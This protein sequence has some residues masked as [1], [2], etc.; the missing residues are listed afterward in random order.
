MRDAPILRR[1]S[2]MSSGRFRQD[3]VLP[4]EQGIIPHPRGA[5]SPP[6]RPNR[7]GEQIE[8]AFPM[9]PMTEPGGMPFTPAL[10]L[11]RTAAALALDGGDLATARAWLATHDRWL[12][13][14]APRRGWADGQLLWAAWRG[15]DRSLQYVRAPGTA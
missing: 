15:P 7:C 1:L 8:R 10:P 12:R 5:C 3:A 4:L 2:A 14:A 9:G 11:L 13:R 6:G